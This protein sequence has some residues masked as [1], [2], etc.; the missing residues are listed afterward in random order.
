MAFTRF[1]EETAPFPRDAV[2]LLLDLQDRILLGT[3][4]PNIPYPYAE[5]LSALA[6]LDLGDGWLRAVCHDNAAGIFGLRPVTPGT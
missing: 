5:A 1:T 6:D 3:D 4:F 2:P